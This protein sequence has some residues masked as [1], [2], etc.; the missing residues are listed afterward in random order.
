M[1]LICN[2][3]TIECGVNG[4][5]NICHSNFICSCFG[6]ND[7]AD[8]GFTF[9]DIRD[10]DFIVE[11]NG[12]KIVYEC[13]KNHRAKLV[14][15]LVEEQKISETAARFT[16]AKHGWHFGQTVLYVKM[17]KNSRGES[18][19][20]GEIA[21]GT[22]QPCFVDA[23]FRPPEDT[24]DRLKAWIERGGPKGEHF[25]Q[26]AGDREAK[27]VFSDDGEEMDLAAKKA[28]IGRINVSLE[29]DAK[30][31]REDWLKECGDPPE[32]AKL[33]MEGKAN[34]QFCWN[35]PVF[36]SKWW[37]V[38]AADRRPRPFPAPKD[39]CKCSAPGVDSVT[40]SAGTCR[41]CGKEI[42][43]TGEDADSFKL[44]GPNRRA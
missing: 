35:H 4:T 25:I 1:K 13:E 31:R 20:C 17:I 41:D 42:C 21:L 43:W 16:L 3:K 30:A 34:G 11:E 40:A 19:P 18:K 14:A 23:T 39:Y 7:L 36:S 24:T 37:E 12:S 9:E 10:H 5:L 27:P 29:A 44:N 38:T 15:R 8:L 26:I 22:P 28:A 2:G 33:I 6:G 32:Q